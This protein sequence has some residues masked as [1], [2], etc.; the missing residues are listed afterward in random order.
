MTFEELLHDLTA[1]DVRLRKI[2][3]QLDVYSSK[4]V[5]SPSLIGGLRSHKGALLAI[6][7]DDGWW[8]PPVIRP[9]MLALVE[10]TQAQI[11]GIVA[12]VPGGA[13]NV[14][15][16][17]PL[18]P[19]QEGML[20]HHL[21]A[22]EGDPYLLAPQ[23]SFDT[24][25]LLDGYVEAL[26]AVVARH[27]IL[28]TAI[29]WEG[30]PEPVQVVWRSAPFTLEEVEIGGGDVAAELYARFDPRRHRMDVRQAPLLRACAAHD[31]R[32]SRWLLQ[33]QRHHLAGDHTTMDVLSGEVEAYLRGRGHELPPALPFRN[34]V[35]QARLGISREEHEAFFRRMLS[36][37]DEPTA[38]FGLLDVQGDGSGIA[39]AR[40]RVDDGLAARLRGRARA[41]GVSAASLCHVAWAQVLAR[42]TGR[43]DVVFGTVLFG[44]MQGSEGADRVVGPLIN[45]LPLRVTVGEEGAEASVRRTHR[46][47]SELLRHEHASLVLAQR[48]SGVRAPAPLFTSLFNYR[49]GAAP[50]QAAEVWSGVRRTRAAEHT[51]FPLALSVD[52][53]GTG[54]GLK[55]QVVAP[56]RAERVCA[57]M[58]R[59][60]EGL[61]DALEHA[62]A[63][64][65]A[66]ID[67]LPE[68]ERRLVVEEWNATDAEYPRDLCVH[69][70]FERQVERTPE[71]VA[72]VFENQALTYAEL[73]ARANRLA[74]HL[75]ALGVG[76]DARVA[77]GLERSPEMVVAVLAVLK[78]GGAYVPLDPTYPAERLQYMLA[79]SAPAVLLTRSSLR[80]LFAA[81]D[82]PVLELDAPAWADA[83]AS[84]PDLGGLTAEH[85][86]YVIYTSGSTGTPKGVMVRHGG[87]AHYVLWAREQYAGGEP[88]SFALYSSFAFD[89]TVTSLYVPL[90]T[91]GSV[92]VYGEREGDEPALLR[93]FDED[94]VDAV[95]LTPSHLVLLRDRDLSAGRIRTLVVGGE[96]LKTPLAHA[97][98]D[99]SAGRMR[100]YNEYGPTEATVGCMIHRYDP[101]RDQDAAVPVG[102]PVWNTRLYLLDAAGAP[103]PVGVAGELYIG[104]VQVAR[105]YLNR[106][107]LTAERFVENPF[108]GGRMYRTGDVARRR[109]DGT[110]EYLGRNDEQVKIRGFRIELGE[111]EARLAEHAAVREVAVVAREDVPGDRRLV[112]Y[113]VGE[114]DATAEALRAHAAERLPEYMVPAAY[115]WL[116]ALPLT[117]NGKLDRR[118]LPA[119]GVD[120]YAAR[121]YEAPVGETEEALAEIW[122]E[123]LGIERVGRNDD[124]FALGGHSLLAVRVVSRARLVLGGEIALADI[125]ASPTVAELAAGFRGGQPRET[126][127]E[128]ILVRPGGAAPPLFLVH[129]GAGDVAY[130]R[131]LHPH[132][133]ADLPVYALPDLPVSAG[134]PATVEGMAA[135][136]VRM[137]RAV[138][139]EGPYRL[140]GWSFGGVLAYEAAAQLAGQDQAVEFLGLLDSDYPARAA[141][142]PLTPLQERMVLVHLLRSAEGLEPCGEARVRELAAVARDATL[143][144]LVDWCHAARILPAGVSV[145]RAREV[146]ERLRANRRA[147]EGYDPRPVPFPVHVFPAEEGRADRTRGWRALLPESSLRVVPVPGTH[148]SMVRPPNAQVLGGALARRMDDA[149]RE[150]GPGARGDHSPLVTLRF[151]RGGGPS[152]FCVPGAGANVVSFADLAGHLDAGWTVHGLQPRGLDGSG[153]PHTS[154]EA[155]AEW[156]LRA[157]RKAQPTGAVH[158]LGHSFGGWVVFEMALRLRREGRR[159]GSL[160]IVDSEPPGE[161]GTLRTEYTGS[162]AFLRFLEVFEHAADRTLDI[163]AG[164]VEGLEEA[165]RLELLHER[166]LGIGF[167][168]QRSTPRLLAGPFRAFSSCLRA[169]YAPTGVYPGP[170]R[171]VLVDDPE[172]GD[173]ENA[174][175]FAETLAGWRRLAP[176]VECSRGGGN[177]MTVLKSPHVHHLAS[178]LADAR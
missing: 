66:R 35:A 140:A 102:R 6:I 162:E 145:A 169:T 1:E 95:K 129:D 65:L 52:D 11:D 131:V 46:L 88:M 56:V 41:L 40:L 130:A 87:L 58:H 100:L 8:Q 71:A 101:A 164:D 174:H 89:L 119:P 21:L 64:P 113:L 165:A 85:L 23:L 152:L 153:L 157:V 72:V 16:I 39:E 2:G 32:N 168:P 161:P 170:V 156:Y 159:V 99:A 108:H 142:A 137:M 138:Q 115:V 80:G 92:V 105:G 126:G 132:L 62:P 146:G 43:Q 73:N 167:L 144:A 25:A 60:L 34:F 148:H 22:T 47:L 49:H 116:D 10:L 74:H 78:A 139:P 17:Y 109:A 120:A 90:V 76:P 107:E 127:H 20:F 147:L 48:G 4:D 94:A 150:Q 79:D 154:V 166:L 37:V 172:C 123:V 54:F 141:A 53:L 59:A 117:P 27:D 86:A 84:N 160:T 149:A 18:A 38:P 175:R 3:D 134:R 110:M 82:V 125:F 121:G 13:A 104:G 28:R 163:A 31:P 155:A 7:G 42:V 83:P 122:A 15:D 81:V 112:A 45:T 143:D 19:M 176:G 111:I 55:V 29:A 63:S 50:S 98:V 114:E 30:L 124:F 67:V 14:Q 171:M 118:A 57:L 178:L 103:V 61:V 70:F 36:D 135:R 51:N 12:T 5:L 93:V 9:D 151:A 24:R 26:R 77:I 69:Q 75:R 136:L 44:R 96:E 173:A 133:G 97:V 128:A 33:L 91:G 68:A 177:H 106:P 158:L